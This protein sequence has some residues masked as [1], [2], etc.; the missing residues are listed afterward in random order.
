MRR[1]AELASAATGAL[2]RINPREPEVRNGRGIGLAAPAA[3][4]LTALDDLLH[5]R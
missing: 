2:V 3:V 5:D 1:E 4:T